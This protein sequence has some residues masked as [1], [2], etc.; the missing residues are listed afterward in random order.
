M[1][2]L[3]FHSTGNPTGLKF[4]VEHGGR[5]CI[6]DFGLEYAP[7]RALFSQGLVPRAGREMA[8]LVAVG[9]APAISGVY[10]VDT[11]DG[12]TAVF[13]SHMHLDHT[14]LVRY[15]HPEVPLFYPAAME[16]VRASAAAAGVV[17]WR[18]P[19]GTPLADREAAHW[20]EIEVVPVAVDHDVP[21]ATGYLIRTPE[22]VI[23]FTG[24]QRWHGL[25]PDL[26]E[27]F[28]EAV[29]GADVLVQEGV[30]LGFE[31]ERRPTERDVVEGFPTVL[32]AHS[33]L[34]V[35]NLM[36]L[37]RER[38]AAFA[39]AANAAGRRLLMEPAAALTAGVGEVLT[40]ELLA[41]V[42][43]QPGRF[44]IQ[45]AFESLPLLIDL[46]PPAG[47]VYVHS[48][49]SPLGA[50]DPA[51]GVMESWTRRFGLEFVSLGSSGHSYLEDIVRTV[52]AVAPGLVLPVHSAAP[53]RLEVPG[54]P[55]L[56]PEPGRVYAASELLT[57]ARA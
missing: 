18:E 2:T 34:V 7:G 5:R 11:W 8:D 45:L 43:A 35:V 36:P 50:W 53:D 44:V 30:Q 38:A 46:A 32:A 28:V 31:P 33:G 26:N 49:G 23:A 20:G 9:A 15:L 4:S 55:R 25:H 10:A 54:V 22:I 56:V 24:D 41:E 48:N 19:S 52:A 27:G 14:S 29:R 51:Y 57:A 39:A 37:N 1:T 47:S 3:T 16:P 13:I 42:R 12:R 40:P 6:F 17:P 21:G